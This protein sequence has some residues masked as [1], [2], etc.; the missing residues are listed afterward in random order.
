M[1][2]YDELNGMF[3]NNYAEDSYELYN[4]DKDSKLF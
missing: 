1:N 2:D 3:N 4:L